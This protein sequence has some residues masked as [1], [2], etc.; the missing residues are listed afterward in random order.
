MYSM[1]LH[2]SIILMRHKFVLCLVQTHWRVSWSQNDILYRIEPTFLTMYENCITME[3][4]T[5][6][7]L[8]P[9][10]GPTSLVMRCECDLLQQIMGIDDG[11]KIL[12]ELHSCAT[13]TLP[14]K[15]ER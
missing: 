8:L 12:V 7:S 9:C 3:G 11:V 13:R 1:Y 6:C 10:F 14:Y 4:Y 15:F 2:I 5:T